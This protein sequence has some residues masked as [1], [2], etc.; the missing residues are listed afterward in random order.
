MVEAIVASLDKYIAGKKPDDPPRVTFGDYGNGVIKYGNQPVASEMV[1]EPVKTMLEFLLPACVAAKRT[2]VITAGFKRAADKHAKG[3]LNP[4]SEWDN[5]S[6][7]SWCAG[8]IGLVI[9]HLQRL[10][11]QKKIYEQ[12][13]KK[14]EG[15]GDIE[16][17]DKFIQMAK[18]VAI[19]KAEPG[20]SSSV[21]SSPLPSPVPS[22]LSS[23]AHS[24]ATSPI[25]QVGV[26]NPV[27]YRSWSGGHMLGAC[28]R[29]E[30]MPTSRLDADDPR[31]DT[32][33]PHPL[34]ADTDGGSK[35][36]KRTVKTAA[37][38]CA[39]TP[40][41][42]DA[43]AAAALAEPITPHKGIT[44]KKPADCDDVT[45]GVKEVAHTALMGIKPE[46]V[47]LEHVPGRMTLVLV[48]AD[49]RA[50]CTVCVEGNRQQWGG[51]GKT[52][53]DACGTTPLILCAELFRAIEK[54][55]LSRPQAADRRDAIA[56]RMSKDT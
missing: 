7:A 21:V 34:A 47:W 26:G 30:S 44:R 15:S 46:S 11:T 45:P 49:G 27:D 40:K 5:G 23:P 53:A 51:F 6:W 16:V 37:K 35:R 39:K 42:Y 56:A 29:Q 54:D 25:G 12:V 4:S 2:V 19:V 48:K 28:L 18:P 55:K 43:H 22:P 32:E 52:E 50:Y 20:L 24:R 1:R 13:V 17:V 41:A 38:K 14:L 10:N 8:S 33:D 36:K 31:L 3:K 9:Q